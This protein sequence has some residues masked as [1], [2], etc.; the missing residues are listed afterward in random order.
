KE[1]APRILIIDDDPSVLELLTELVEALGFT[2]FTAGSGEAGIEAAHKERPDLVLLDVNLPGIDGFEVCRRLK[3][4]R[5]SCGIPVI[6]LTTVANVDSRVRGM[7]LGADD[8]LGKPFGAN[9][10]SARIKLCLR[11]TDAAEGDKR[12]EVGNLKV[13]RRS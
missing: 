9:E 11:R 13:D 4:S 2:S 7:E 6:L 1:P 8:Y 10:L 5:E 12:I 3:S